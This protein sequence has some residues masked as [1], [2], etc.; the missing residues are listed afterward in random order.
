MDTAKSFAVE[1]PCRV[2]RMDDVTPLLEQL[3]VGA[4]D[5]AVDQILT[6]FNEAFVNVVKH[7]QL[8]EADLVEVRASRDTGRVV[9]EL[10]DGGVPFDYDPQTMAE[11]PPLLSESGMGLFIIQSYMNDVTYERAERNVLTMI[12]Y[13]EC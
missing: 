3:C 2:E 4:D 12:R 6:A 5:L 1:V 13:L 11:E 8:G 9:V 10:I 7:S